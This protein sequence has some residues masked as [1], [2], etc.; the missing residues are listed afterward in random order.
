VIA[1]WVFIR[2]EILYNCTWDFI[3]FWVFSCF[4]G[5]VNLA[6]WVVIRQFCIVES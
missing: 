5:Q 6:V 3:F 1:V 2:V 4:V